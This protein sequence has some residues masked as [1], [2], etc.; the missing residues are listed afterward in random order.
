MRRLNILDVKLHFGFH[1]WPKKIGKISTFHNF[2][3]GLGP[4]VKTWTPKRRFTIAPKLR[5]PSI[6]E[7]H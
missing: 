6:H 1:C 2:L 3:L 4:S 7:A 5:F